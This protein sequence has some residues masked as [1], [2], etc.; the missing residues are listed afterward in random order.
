MNEAMLYLRKNWRRISRPFGRRLTSIAAPGDYYTRH[1]HQKKRSFS[2]PRRH[3]LAVLDPRAVQSIRRDSF[4]NA[5]LN[6]SDFSIDDSE[7]SR[8]IPT[9]QEATDEEIRE[10]RRSLSRR[11]PSLRHAMEPKELNYSNNDDLEASPSINE[12][13]ETQEQ[14]SSSNDNSLDRDKSAED[15]WIH[16]K[17]VRTSLLT[18][19]TA[20]Y[21]LG[22]TILALVFE[23]AHL[24]SEESE[25]Q[26]T[27]K[28]LIFGLFMYGGSIIFFFYMYV[29][30]MMRPKWI[31]MMPVLQRFVTR[32][33]RRRK[34]ALAAIG[35]KTE[36]SSEV[37]SAAA[38]VRRVSHNGPSAG[39]LFLRL[40]CIVFGIV[41]LVYYA[42]LVFLCISDHNCSALNV[43]LDVCAIV[44]IFVQM[45]FV[46]TNW[47]LTLFGSHFIARLGTMHLVSANLWTWIR[48]VLME[49]GVMEREIREVFKMIN[50]TDTS[51]HA[52][53]DSSSSEEGAHEERPHG[54]STLQTFTPTASSCRA[55]E[56][57]LGS[58]SEIMFTSIVEYSLIAAA[59]M[60]IVW[61]NIGRHDKPANGYVKRKHQI[62]VDCSKT[63][64]GLF[65]GLAFIAITLTSM[66]IY[67]GYT[68]LGKSENAAFVYAFTDI[69]QYATSTIGCIIAIYQ[70]RALKYLTNHTAVNEDQ[71]LLD[72]ILICV[73]LIGELIYSIAGLVGLT[74]ESSWESL[75]FVLLFVHISRLIQITVQTLLLYVANRVRVKESHFDSQPGK[76]AVTFLLAANVAMFMMNL[77]ESEKAGVSEIIID[78][79]GK[80]S[81]VILVRCFS[82]LTIFFRFHSSVVLA[83]IWKNVYARKAIGNGHHSH[84]QSNNMNASNSVSSDLANLQ[85]KIEPRRNSTE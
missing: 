33:C 73:G 37:S 39:S 24:L 1:K 43:S 6:S 7:A 74:G 76:Q 29:V 72:Q 26:I 45:H 56:C 67:Y 41:G 66:I 16:N 22:V 13:E 84:N 65:L 8:E 32:P 82:P 48:Y 52:K 83:E 27:K 10:L 36:V 18:A 71:E 77:F 19:L 2:L 57:I 23:L 3:S 14:G 44:F 35:E 60:Y 51:P 21:C 5:W 80:R 40:G 85:E 58:L 55:A 15:M 34:I 28:D 78:F 20:F 11:H 4:T 49:E 31:S 62:R 59:V 47:K 17:A 53:E 68:I 46:F 54:I 9:V 42:F 79:Y 70:M 69:F 64:T 81:W 75:T 63:T 38:T 30:L 61:R 12:D 25:R 50:Q